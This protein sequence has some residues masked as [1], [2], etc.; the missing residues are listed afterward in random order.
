MHKT[1]PHI[2]LKLFDSNVNGTKV[3]QSCPEGMQ[4]KLRGV[5]NKQ[6]GELD[7]GPSTESVS[8]PHLCRGGL[9]RPHTGKWRLGRVEQ[10]A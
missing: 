1:A 5:A 2:R 6:M 3:D 4:R 9:S 7:A 10:P 8:H